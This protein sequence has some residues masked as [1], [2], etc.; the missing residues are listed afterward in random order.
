MIVNNTIPTFLNLDKTEG[1]TV[2]DLK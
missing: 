1:I 2:D